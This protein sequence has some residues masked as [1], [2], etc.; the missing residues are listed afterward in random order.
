MD[1]NVFMTSFLPIPSHHFP[2]LIRPLPSTIYSY[3]PRRYCLKM[4]IEYVDSKIMIQIVENTTEEEAQGWKGVGKGM[5]YFTI[6]FAWEECL[7]ETPSPESP[8][9]RGNINKTSWGGQIIYR[10]GGTRSR[11]KNWIHYLWGIQ[12]ETF[13]QFP[14]PKWTYKLS[15][16]LGKN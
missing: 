2:F 7:F 12:D 16:L 8:I 9:Q 4:L 15:E 11:G 10:K 13:L 5:H 14:S 6:D 3:I 1:G